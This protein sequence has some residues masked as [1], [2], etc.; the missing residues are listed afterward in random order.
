MATK[1]EA[2]VQQGILELRHGFDIEPTNLHLLARRYPDSPDTSYI[3]MLCYSQTS[4]VIT[5]FL[6][7]VSPV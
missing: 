2:Y 5:P 4:T 6:L 7:A 3:V 1:L